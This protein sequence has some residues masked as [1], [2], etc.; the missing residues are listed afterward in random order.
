MTHTA[1]ILE[2]GR[3]ID[4]T[5]NQCYNA[6]L[7]EKLIREFEKRNFEGFYCKTKDAAVSKIL[8]ILPENATVSCGGSVSLEEIGLTKV[9]TDGS[10]TFL[11]PNGAGNALDK[12]VIAHKALAS[13]YYFMSSN[14]VCESGELVNVDGYGNRVSALIFGPKNVI[15]VVGLNKVEGS[16]E[17]AVNRAKTYAARK[18][19]LK[20]KQDYSSFEELC[21]AAEAACSQLVITEKSA[22]KGRIKIILVG[23]NLGF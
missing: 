14:A 1:N 19:L 2:R 3:F 23:E 5:P 11:N 4:M 10:Y 20:F 17:A 22:V 6:L 7:A 21:E 18:I 15:I 9:L 16:L 12:D 13:D 8:D